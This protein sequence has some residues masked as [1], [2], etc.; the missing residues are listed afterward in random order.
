MGAYTRRRLAASVVLGLAAVPFSAGLRLAHGFTLNIG[1]IV[2]GFGLGLAVGLTE[3]FVLNRWRPSL[4]FAIHLVV[5]SLLLVA[6]MFVAFALLNVL[7]VF[8]AGI[9]W[10]QYADAVFSVD[11]A[12]GLTEALGVV[13]LLLF[14][15]Q[16]DR[17]LG[18]GRLLGYVT[19]RYH[20]ARHEERIVMFLDLDAS[21]ALAEQ[22]GTDRYLSFLQRYF[23]A[24]SEAILE[25]RAEIY[26]YVGDQ[27]ILT[28]KPADG[29]REAACLGVFFR[30]ED[31]MQ[32]RREEFLRDFGMVP[33]FKAGVHVGQ[34]VVAQIGE[35]KTEIE[36]S[37]DVLNTAARI[38]AHC[39]PS[40]HALLASADVIAR[41]APTHGFA[42]I[43]L[44]LV[45]LRGKS[46]S[47]EL[48]AVTRS[49]T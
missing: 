33:A 17:L 9:S 47:L 39:R 24:M 40:G 21:T 22:L 13:G 16:L 11:L 19:G 34:V 45:P 29:I 2:I 23:A 12:V 38:E 37:G 1:T 44:G 36:Y 30:I 32:V 31:E 10:A 20:R 7:D 43:T 15:V 25:T 14:F 3:F 41:L 46:E 49:S 18:P 35:L 6:A 42:V 27:V 28:W 5:K 8:L 4:P 48:C 26:K